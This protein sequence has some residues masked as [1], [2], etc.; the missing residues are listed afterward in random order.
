VLAA[1]TVLA[2]VFLSGVTATFLASGRARPIVVA[3]VAGTASGIVGTQVPNARPAITHFMVPLIVAAM[4]A[5]VTMKRS[6]WTTFGESPA[7][8]PSSTTLGII[9]IVAGFVSAY[10]ASLTLI[11]KRCLNAFGQNIVGTMPGEV[12]E[13]RIA[14]AIPGF[15]IGCFAAII[16][17]KLLLNRGRNKT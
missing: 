6:E 5:A 16:L 7:T 12:W 13:I 2:A 14:G 17:G 15:F 3:L 9:G 10:L 8:T 11:G 1:L 4:A